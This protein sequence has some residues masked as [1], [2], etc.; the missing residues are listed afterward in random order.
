MLTGQELGAAIEA[1]RLMKGV[2]KKAMAEHFEVKPP[3]IQDWVAR[4]TI[5]KDMLEKVWFYFRDV[6]GPTH[7]GLP[8]HWTFEPTRAAGQW[9]FLK[10]PLEEIDGLSPEDKGYLQGVIRATLAEIG[11]AAAASASADLGNSA[12]RQTAPPKSAAG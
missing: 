7:W 8:A 5:D 11:R 1:A 9:P 6:V 10:I 2:T 4:G 3:S 12:G